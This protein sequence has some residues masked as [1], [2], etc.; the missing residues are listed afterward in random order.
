MVLGKLAVCSKADTA[1][2]SP[3]GH[4]TRLTSGSTDSGTGGSSAHGLPRSNCDHRTHTDAG[5]FS[6]ASGDA[7]PPVQ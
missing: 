2:T 4:K 6:A 5:A 7:S 1:G 3:D